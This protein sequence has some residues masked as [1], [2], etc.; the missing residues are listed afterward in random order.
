[1]PTSKHLCG[2]SSIIR[3]IEQPLGMAGVIP[4]MSG[5]VR[6]NSSKV[7]PKTSWNLVF[8]GTSG[9]SSVSLCPVSASKSPGACQVGWSFS[10]G[11]YP[12]PFIVRAC[13]SRGPFRF[14]SLLKVLTRR[15]T[16]CP[17]TGPKYRMPSG[18]NNVLFLT[19][20]R[21]PAF[22]VSW[23]ASRMVPEPN[24]FHVFIFSLL[25][26]PDVVSFKRELCSPPTFGS[27]D[28]LLSLST[29]SISALHPPALFKPSYASPAV[30]EPSPITATVFSSL[31]RMAA[32]VAYPRAA[33][34]DVEECP[35]PKAS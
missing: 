32:A 24:A 9:S 21:F 22:T 33:D 11:A 1:M 17:S 16:S 23:I 29:I 34:M 18:W 25:Y 5:L 26:L 31:L 14:F 6:A 2:I 8:V 3:F 4:V 13:S 20:R 28:I 19:K 27:I 10:A 12:F 30:M 15:M 7:W 35:V